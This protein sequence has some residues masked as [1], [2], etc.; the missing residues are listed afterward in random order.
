MDEL[1]AGADLRIGEQMMHA[2]RHRHHDEQDE[3][4]ARHG[5]AVQAPADRARKDRV[6]GDI[7]RHQ[8]EIDDG[9][10]RPGEEHARQAGIDRGLEAERDRQD[11]DDHSIAA[12]TAVQPHR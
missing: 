5:V 6:I 3:G 7:G 12:P 9:V 1:E 4:D 10:Q 2:D 8:P 11:Q